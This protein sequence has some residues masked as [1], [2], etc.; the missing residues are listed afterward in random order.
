MNTDLNEAGAQAGARHYLRTPDGSVYGPV[1]IA[2]LCA[3][4]ADARVIPGCV[5][6]A[7]RET[8]QPVETYPELRL[9]WSVQFEDGTAY[10]PLNLLAIWV[11]ASEESIPKGVVLVE[12]ETGRKVVLNESIYPSLI[13]ECRQVLSGCGQLISRELSTLSTARTDAIAL[14]AERDASL[15]E[16]RGYLE[17]TRVTLADRESQLGAL[18][19][20]LA[21]TESDLDVNL[22]LVAETQRRLAESVAHA[23]LASELADLQNQLATANSE[24]S[25]LEGE[26]AS[27]LSQLEEAG[28]KLSAEHEA[29]VAGGRREQEALTTVAGLESILAAS[30][31]SLDKARD[32]AANDAEILARLRT[33]EASLRQQL[34]EAQ[35]GIVDRDHQLLKLESTLAD[36]RTQSEQQISHLESRLNLSQ[37]ARVTEQERARQ[38]ADALVQLRADLDALSRRLQELQTDLQDKTNVIRTQESA[39]AVQQ[40]EADKRI[41]LLKSTIKMLENDL[42]LAT[43]SV[44]NLTIQLNQA[45]ETAANAQK[46]GRA[47]EQK[48]KEELVAIQADLNGLMLASRFVKQI[49]SSSKNNPID[50]MEG[51][52]SSPASGEKSGDLEARFAKLSMAEKMVLLQKELRAS[53]EQKELMRREL[54]A[55]NSRYE[56]LSKDSVDRSRESEEK[57]A[58]LQKEVKT[59]AELLARTMQ[60]LEKRESLVREL[61]KKTGNPGSGA[62]VKSAVM[63]A[64]VIHS[65]TLG[66]DEAAHT[67]KKP[68]GMDGGGR[69][70][71]SKPAAETMLNSVEAQ[72]QRELKHW[73]NLKRE[74]D[75]KEGTR[76]KWFRWKSS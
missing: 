46:A 60:E 70:A 65:E 52:G 49:S 67:E 44:Q 38:D 54:A 18:R 41:S 19:F 20:K 15:D 10:G 64:E 66:P 13:Q 68:G 57:L 72:L 28:R 3:W 23:S 45:K 58:Q 32:Q 34:Q 21:Q 31:R 11:L 9:N 59:S 51:G 29:N 75:N 55:M 74:K 73:E 22:K 16:L 4:A 6:S 1:D 24:V 53:A 27:T 36:A 61:R 47:A 35:T 12:K 17:T 5:L 2:T 26:L 8:W 42:Q 56:L 43:Q 40:T 39:M 37:Q 7:D 63:D 71:N 69:D 33:S 25:R 62:P 76:G 50:W 30:Q 14:L 48:Q